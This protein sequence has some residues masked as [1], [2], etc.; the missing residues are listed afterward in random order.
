LTPQNNT[1]GKLPAALTPLIECPHWVIWRWEF[2]ETGERTK[3]PYQARAPRY[4]ASTNK[5]STWATFEEA[6]AALRFADGIGF[7]LTDSEFAA[8]DIDDC[9]NA[10]TG[11][12]HPWASNLMAQAGSYTEITPSGEGVRIIGRSNGPK[13]PDTKLAVADGVTC[14]FYRKAVRYIT[15]TGDQ[16]GDTPIANIDAVMDAAY[17]E[18]EER[19]QEKPGSAA[20]GGHHA[21]HIEL[22]DVIQNGCYEHFR[23]DRNRAV[24]YVINEGMRLGW[25]DDKIAAT[26]LNRENEIS[27]HNYE[28]H[29]ENPKKYVRDQIEKARKQQEARVVSAIDHMKRARKF[30][31]QRRPNLRYWRGEFYDW[32]ATSYYAALGKDTITS[33]IWKYLEQALIR[34][35]QGALTPFYPKRNTVEET[36]AALKAIAQLEDNRE[37]PFWIAGGIAGELIAF[38][39]GL[40][41]LSSNKLHPPNPD[42]F[43]LGALGFNY[44]PKRADPEAWLEF[45][46]QVFDKAHNQVEAHAQ[47]E[48][49]QEIFGYLLTGD[50]SQE[51]CFMLLGPPRS[52]KGTMAR[53]IEALL[54]STTVAGPALSDFGTEF[55]LSA[56]IGKQLAII[57]DLRVARKDQNLMVENVLKISGRGHFTIN[58]KFLSFWTGVL[59]VKLVFISNEMP[60]LGDDSPALSGRFII[61]TTRQSFLGRED[62][63]LFKTR[64]R[65]ELVDVFH[66]ALD[67]LRRLRKN[68]RFTEPQA[69]AEARAQMGQL[70]S[71]VMAF[72]A[73]RCE[74]N[75]YVSENKNA[76]YNAYKEYAA[77]NE[78]SADTK[79]KFFTAL[80]AATSGKVKPVR[81]GG[82]G[83][84]VPS[85]Q[86]IKL[87]N[88]AQPSSQFYFQGDPGWRPPF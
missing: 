70:G 60:R 31:A 4:K 15:M 41:E 23:N 72:I 19:K 6:V 74:L 35:K 26:L 21:R 13:L 39:N 77:E 20:D 76:L 33:E 45:L 10:Q 34:D 80:Y 55:G 30:R 22:D 83:K 17:A 44:Q 86:G 24:W 68:G 25:N 32:V 59:P 51:K 56:L 78:M 81:I 7:V 3:V 40:L 62:P 79:E 50:I 11:V 53:M 73:E 1:E 18:L 54:A 38:P 84:Q 5:V 52:G 66:W 14:E 58:R 67:G 43:A 75:P 88:E 27:R 61:L 42:F 12:I 63:D 37:T 36:L 71:L 2:T 8:F 48:A 29:P 28:A 49:L 47:I 64:L 57:D 69:S 9:R 16:I 46:D 85:C 87:R 65:P 82:A